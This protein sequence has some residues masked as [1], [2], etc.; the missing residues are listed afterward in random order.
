MS[1]PVVIDIETKNTFREVGSYEPTMLNVSLVGFYDYATNSY[2]T[3]LENELDK[4][5]PKLE[6]SSY[7]IGFNS[8]HFDIPILNKYYAGD[9]LQLLQFDI[10]KAFKEVL[11]Q[12][13]KLDDL[14]KATLGYGK[15]GD[16]LEAIALW[17]AGNIEALKKYCLDDVR[18][19]KEIY[20][21]ARKEGWLKYSTPLGIKQLKVNFKEPRATNKKINFTLPF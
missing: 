15:S 14:A 19:T 18:I 13:V 12:G 11:G 1:H 17:K 10:L 7:I 4:L 3:F 5:W 21:H 20:D 2:E 9:L 6:R 8:E 16:G